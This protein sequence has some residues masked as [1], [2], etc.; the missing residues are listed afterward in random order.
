[1]PTA[2]DQEL[3]GLHARRVALGGPVHGQLNAALAA[4]ASGEADAAHGIAGRDQQ[5]NEQSAAIDSGC[6]APW[7]ARPRS[8]RICAWSPGCCTSTST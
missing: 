3:A 2:F 6:C 5:I 7:A 1:M 8:P 4:L